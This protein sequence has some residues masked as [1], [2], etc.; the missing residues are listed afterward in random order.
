MSEAMVLQPVLSPDICVRALEARDARFDGVFFVGITSTSIYCRP[1]CPARVSR[2]HHRRFFDSAAR[3]ERAGFRPCRRCRPELAPGRALVDA[4][5]QLARSA[6]QRIAAGALN[7]R[8]VRQLAA[9]L[10]VCERHLRR[11]LERELGVSPVELAQTH[12]LLLAKHLLTDTTLSITRVAEAS[13]FQSLRRFNAVFLERY[14]MNP[15]SLRRNGDRNSTGGARQPGPTRRSGLEGDRLGLSLSYR[16]PYAWAVTLARLAGDSIP[17]V[18]H[19]RGTRFQRTVR[20]DEYTGVVEVEIQPTETRNHAA[21]SGTLAVRLS[22]S[23]LPVLMPLLSRLRHV[24]DLDAEPAV[25]DECL[26]EGGLREL[27]LARPGVRIVGAL[28]GFEAGFRTLL[29]G[30]ADRRSA[31]RNAVIRRVV[32]EL[33]EPIATGVPGLGRLLPT[34]ATVAEAG[35][36][37]LVA[38][39]VPPTR[40]RSLAALAHAIADGQIQLEPGGDAAAARTALIALPGIGDGAASEIAMRAL[41]WP[42]A[43]PEADTMLQRAAGAPTRSALRTR[44]GS[45]RPWRAYAAVHLRIHHASH[46]HGTLEA[47]GHRPQ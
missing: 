37:R 9:E 21:G 10:C 36:S 29:T 35:S 32:L 39:G 6:A 20:I 24:F 34:A 17:G 30:N 47:G 27:V 14:R 26:A 33:G 19:V 4:V 41:G 22:T 16:R 1:V 40:A 25:V 42:D 38:L 15:S 11:A 5:S 13:G 3:A 46:G 44:A 31:M 2:P 12:R 7:G 43:F 23:L 18:E 45:W 28:D 8:P